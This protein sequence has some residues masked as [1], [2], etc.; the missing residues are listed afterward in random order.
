MSL[1]FNWWK[2]EKDK[3]K[4]RVEN[5]IKFVNDWEMKKLKF[6]IIKATLSFFAA[7]FASYL[8]YKLTGG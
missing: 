1:E 6:K 2:S 7:L 5:Y 8:V 3:E 4:Q